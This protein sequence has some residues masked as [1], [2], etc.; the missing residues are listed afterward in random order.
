MTITTTSQSVGNAVNN[1]KVSMAKKPIIIP[2]QN[3]ER[4]VKMTCPTGSFCKY[5]VSFFL[6][7][8]LFITP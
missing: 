6:K 3:R 7:F 1:P 5:M 8:P 2:M 4:I